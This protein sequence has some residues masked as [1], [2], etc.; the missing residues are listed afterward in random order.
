MAEVAGDGQQRQADLPAPRKGARSR[1]TQEGGGTQY[2]LGQ[3]MR[4]DASG[5]TF[6][7]TNLKTA[8]DVAGTRVDD[9]RTL[10]REQRAGVR[11]TVQIVFQDPYSSL[12]PRMTVGDIVG[13]P[14]I[15][16]GIGSRRENSGDEKIAASYR[17]T[18]GSRNTHTAGLGRERSMWQRHVQ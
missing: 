15:V 9:Y 7:V 4:P 6:T 10:T 14:L 5:Q 1:L 8:I 11:R 12:D 18:K 3:D 17:D 16:H 2:N 13:E